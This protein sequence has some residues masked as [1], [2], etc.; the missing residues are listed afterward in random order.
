MRARCEVI[1]LVTDA[2]QCAFLGKLGRVVAEQVIVAD[3]AIERERH[4]VADACRREVHAAI[5]A[6]R[7]EQQ[8]RLV[9][10]A[11][12][13]KCLVVQSHRDDIRTDGV[14]HL[15]VLVAIDIEVTVGTLGLERVTAVIGIQVDHRRAVVVILIIHLAGD[16]DAHGEVTTIHA[17]HIDCETIRTIQIGH[18]TAII[19]SIAMSRDRFL[20]AIEG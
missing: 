6:H 5:I 13:D 2:A 4:A 8:G 17:I 7:S 9:D 1:Q 10:I 15:V 18:L 11:A 20:A 3:G 14:S 16:N 12:V 19:P